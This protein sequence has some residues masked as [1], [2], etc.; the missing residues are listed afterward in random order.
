[1]KP[2]IPDEMLM[3]HADGELEAK[4]MDAM[5]DHLAGDPHLRQRLRAFTETN[6]LAG[7]FDEIMSRP[8]PAAL[9]DILSA[10]AATGTATTAARAEGGL[11]R[12]LA[13]MFEI[14]RAPWALGMALFTCV[15]VGAA[16]GWIVSRLATSPTAP[17]LLAT[18]ADGQV[19]AGRLLASALETTPMQVTVNGIEGSS[20][21]PMQIRPVASFE[22]KD[23]RPCRQFD[24]SIG[25]AGRGIE[26]VACRNAFGHWA[27]EGQAATMRT[28]QAKSKEGEFKTLSASEAM[29]GV[30]EMLMSGAKF[31]PQVERKWLDREWRKPD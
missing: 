20:G 1:M 24:V 2:V 15:V 29:D 6:R 17:T 22:A 10:P 8:V 4:E 19:I 14:P 18:S 7:P 30:I 16:T 5:R 31:A 9:N 28:A 3:A 21:L 13:A 23:H 27:I 26:G 12:T 11:L 25:S